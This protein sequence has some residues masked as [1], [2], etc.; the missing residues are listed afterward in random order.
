MLNIQFQDYN[1]MLGVNNQDFVAIGKQH[2]SAEGPLK[3]RYGVVIC[4]YYMLL[5][6]Y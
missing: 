2:A 4:C 6:D 3:G 5:H 1:Q